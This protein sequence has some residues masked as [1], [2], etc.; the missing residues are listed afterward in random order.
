MEREKEIKIL[1]AIREWVE[2][3][4]FETSVDDEFQLKQKIVKIVE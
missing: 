4:G 1:E 2:Y 3:H